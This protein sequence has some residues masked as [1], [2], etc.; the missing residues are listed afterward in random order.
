MSKIGVGIGQD[1]P[2]DDGKPAPR[3]NGSGEHRDAGTEKARH[4]AD[5]AARREA[6]RNWREQRREW[7]R[8]WRKEWR[9][10]Q[11][12]FRRQVHQNI[13]ENGG[14]PREHRSDRQP[15]F[16]NYGILW[17]VL[18]VIVAIAI[19]SFI[20]SNIFTVVGIVALLALFVA[21]QRGQDP[22]AME[23]YDYSNPT[24]AAAAPDTAH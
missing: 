19:T 9:A 15:D 1:F 24:P 17:A 6:Y 13:Y 12:A 3:E 14:P 20:F 10:R 2:A 23:T 4:N 7:K 8:Q 21:Y 22:F 11:R 16:W 5:C 18:G